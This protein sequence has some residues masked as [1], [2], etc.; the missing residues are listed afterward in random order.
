MAAVV[1]HREQSLAEHDALIAILQEEATAAAHAIVTFRDRVGATGLEDLDVGQ[2]FE[3]LHQL[4]TPVPL[5][6]LEEQEVSGGVLLGIT[7]SEMATVLKIYQHAGCEAP[8]GA[9]AAA[10]RRPRRL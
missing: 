4:N 10:H 3:L 5:A 1:A 9:R 7:E 8:T 2:V 6:V